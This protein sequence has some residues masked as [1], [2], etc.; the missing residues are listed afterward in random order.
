MGVDRDA[1]PVRESQA[2]SERGELHHP[3]GGNH[4]PPNVFEKMR[5]V[6]TRLAEI[7][8]ANRG[9]LWTIER[10]RRVLAAI[11]DAD[12]TYGIILGGGESATPMMV[13]RDAIVEA[14]YG[15]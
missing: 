4:T 10:L 1:A 8:E 12:V 6:E 9:E 7:E 15:D 5:H 2:P 11:Q 3:G 13:E 14:L